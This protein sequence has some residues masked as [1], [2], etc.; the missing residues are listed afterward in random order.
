MSGK[1]SRNPSLAML[2]V[3]KQPELRNLAQQ[4]WRSYLPSFEN[5]AQHVIGFLSQLFADSFKKYI[6]LYLTA[7]ILELRW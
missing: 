4:R 6:S 2:Q 3:V 5:Y 1:V 7:E